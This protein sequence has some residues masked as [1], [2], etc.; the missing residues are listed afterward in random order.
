MNDNTILYDFDTI[1]SRLL[2]GARVSSLLPAFERIAQG[3]AQ[4]PKETVVASP[5]FL[6]KNEELLKYHTVFQKNFGTFLN[7]GCASIPFLLEELIRVGIAINKMAMERKTPLY[8]YET[9]SADG[10]V[11][12]T[13]AEYGMGKIHTLTDSPNEAN[14]TEFYRLLNHKYS[15]FHRGCFAE[16]TPLFISKKY[17][18]FANGFDIIWENTTFQLYGNYRQEQIAYVKRLLAKN[19]IMIFLEKMLHQNNTEYLRRETLKE[20]KF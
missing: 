6:S 16:I 9:S 17:P 18:L 19:G 10:T 7:H 8:Y 4:K 3:S 11:A 5:D 2:C 1:Q 14:Q 15:F 20:E 13:L 12:R